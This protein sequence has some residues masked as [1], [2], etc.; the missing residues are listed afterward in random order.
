VCGGG[1]DLAKEQPV[2]HTP[3]DDAEVLEKSSPLKSMRGLTMQCVSRDF[4]KKS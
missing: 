1:G 3:T 2:I 4:G